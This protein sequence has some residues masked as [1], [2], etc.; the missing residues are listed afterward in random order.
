LDIM[1]H[2]LW[3]GEQPS[4]PFKHKVMGRIQRWLI[5]SALKTW[6]PDS[7]HTSNRLYQHVLE[8]HGYP[9]ERLPIFGN[10]PIAQAPLTD[11]FTREADERIVLFPFSQR[12]DWNVGQTLGLLDDAA[13]AAGVRLKLVQIGSLRS[14]LQHWDTIE[15]F[16]QVNG[17]QCLRLGAQPEEIVS[18]WMLSADIGISSAHIL[19]ADKS[20]AA[21]A[22]HEHGLPVICTI[23]E[24]VSNRFKAIP[25]PDEGFYSFF[26]DTT[27]LIELFRNPPKRAPQ[28]RLTIVATKWL[29]HLSNQTSC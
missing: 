2:E 15:T 27:T 5:L 26:D 28:A 8:R 24:P 18:Q 16:A 6:K 3:V 9:S 22:M 20:G 21:V 13:R 29:E 10:I 7:I 12:H 14:G 23:T 19:L 4:L 1:F 25:K 11:E 17:W